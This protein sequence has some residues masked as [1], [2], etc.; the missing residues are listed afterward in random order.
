M[1]ILVTG[2]AGFIGSHTVVELH[3]A[4]YQPVVLDNFYNSKPGVMD[5]LEKITGKKFP[6]YQTDCNDF[7]GLDA[8]FAKEQF[9]GVIHFAAYKAVGESV[10]QPL[11]YYQNNLGTLLNLLELC[12]KHRVRNFV[13]SSSCTVYGEPDS[14]PV[15]ESTPRKPATSPY[16]NTKSICEDIIRDFVLSK[17]PVRAISL[18]Y[19]NPIGAHPSAEIGELP[20]GVP[21]NLV[22]YI[23]QVAA[24]IR[25]KLSVFGNDYDTPDGTCIRDF[26]H[27]TDLAKAH[28]KALEKINKTDE[29]SYYD[30]FNVGTGQGHSVLEVITTFEQV[31]H[32]RLNYSFEPRRPGDVI[33]IYAQSDK[34]NS[35]LNWKAEKTLAESLSDAWRWQQ[36]LMSEAPIS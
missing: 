18:R 6:L 9:D 4:G 34:I 35:E 5:G 16:G 20:L 32:L 36:K 27:V 15:T 10:E 23:T 25:G 12:R 30:V 31:N 7:D 13:F 2:G 17:A 21:G 14:L 19:F 24:G 3:D 8:V 11:M 28:V 1:K 26:I 22:P 33:K 29:A